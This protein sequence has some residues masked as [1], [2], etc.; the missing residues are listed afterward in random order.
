[1]SRT[2]HHTRRYRALENRKN[3]MPWRKISDGPPRW[4]KKQWQG[5]IRSYHKE[6][7]LR[8]PEDPFLTSPRRIA[9]LWDWF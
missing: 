9:N 7:M 5:E 6:E 2:F 8:N 3:G 1:M 4:L